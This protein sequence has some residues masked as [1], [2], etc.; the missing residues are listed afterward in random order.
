MELKLSKEEVEAILMAHVNS[1]I[2]NA[3]FNEIEWEDRYSS[4]H[5][6]TFSHTDLPPET[7]DD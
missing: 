1:V 5:G 6:A 3:A 2:P 4:R 7:A